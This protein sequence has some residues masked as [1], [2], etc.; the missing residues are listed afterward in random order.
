M[1]ARSRRKTTDRQPPVPPEYAEHVE[2]PRY[3]K[4]PRWTGLDPNPNSPGVHLHWN[5]MRMSERLLRV[6]EQS[7]GWRPAFP[8]DGSRMIRGTAVA[9]DLSLQTP[10][11][12][13]V[14]HYYDLDKVCR[15]CG[16]RFIFFAEE[17]K[18]W[19]EDLGFP[20]EADCTR[21]P[22]CRKKLQWIGRKR[23]RYEQLMHVS[24]RSPDQTLE[25][26]ECCLALIEQG[27]F[28]RRQTEHVRMLLNTI[29]EDRRAAQAYLSLRTRLEIIAKEQK[30]SPT[31]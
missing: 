12:V 15:D 18:H 6:I 25:M 2:H 11:T 26:A 27:I 24:Q 9:A 4:G 29:P 7:L 13:P 23:K 31:R 20:L 19:Y 21:C 3:G 5:T 22:P 30:T 17:Q 16:R 8:D 14:T 10:A 1:R 28:H